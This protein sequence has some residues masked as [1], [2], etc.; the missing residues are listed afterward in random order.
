MSAE[1]ENGAAA[2]SVFLENLKQNGA[3]AGGRDGAGWLEKR[4]TLLEELIES[5]SKWPRFDTMP[6]AYRAALENLVMARRNHLKKREDIPVSFVSL[7]FDSVRALPKSYDQ[8]YQA[9]LKYGARA[10]NTVVCIAS[11]LFTAYE[12]AMRNNSNP[13]DSLEPV[14]NF[15]SNMP[16]DTPPDG[17]ISMAVVFSRSITQN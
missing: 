16:F 13:D 5:T 3:D 14:V 12:I 10:T 2:I 4:A 1:H 15:V 6:P 9:N 17:W 7:I 8:F 11:L